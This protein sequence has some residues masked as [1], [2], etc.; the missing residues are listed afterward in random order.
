MPGPVGATATEAQIDNDALNP[1]R[2]SNRQVVHVTLQ[3]EGV[4]F[5]PDTLYDALNSAY[6]TVTGGKNVQSRDTHIF[7]IST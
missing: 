3:F 5:N 2:S 6:G 4:T 1:P 7:I